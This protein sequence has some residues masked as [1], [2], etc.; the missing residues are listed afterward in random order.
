MAVHFFT[1]KA[2]AAKEV[3]EMCTLPAFTPITPGNGRQ[4][5]KCHLLS[6]GIINVQGP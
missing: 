4:M 6:K 5:H 2:A 1:L 3:T